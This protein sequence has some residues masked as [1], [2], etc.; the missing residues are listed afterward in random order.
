MSQLGEHLAELHRNNKTFRE[1]I[2]RANDSPKP[3]EKQRLL[4]LIER[5]DIL[6][7]IIGTWAAGVQAAC[8]KRVAA[9]QG[10]QIQTASGQAIAIVGDKDDLAALDSIA[11]DNGY[12]TLSSVLNGTITQPAPAAGS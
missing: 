5:Q 12:A 7:T 10:I 6:L 8:D 3:G 2:E 11:T 4:N 9:A 1:V